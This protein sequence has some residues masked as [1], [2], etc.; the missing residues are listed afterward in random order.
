MGISHL[1]HPNGRT[2]YDSNHS[3]LSRLYDPCDGNILYIL[4]RFVGKAIF[5]AV[6][7]P[8]SYVPITLLL[9]PLLY[10]LF[11]K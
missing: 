2:S 8:T 5:A 6:G 9:I 7:Y 3:I 10:L 11:K 4:L 1:F